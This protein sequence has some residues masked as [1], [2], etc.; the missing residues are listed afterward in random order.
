MPWV[1]GT[2]RA[3]SGSGSTGPS[4][5]DSPWMSPAT[6]RVRS[7]GRAHPAANGT[8]AM[9]PTRATA[10]ALR[11][12]FS[13]VWFPATVRHREQLY[14][15]AAVGEQ[16]R[17]GV[18]VPGVAVEEDLAGHGGQPF[19]GRCGRRANLSD[20]GPLVA[21]SVDAVPR[22]GGDGRRA[23]WRTAAP[24]T[25]TQSDHGPLDGIRV[26]DFST[27]Y[28]GPITAMLL[29]D[30]GADVLKIELPTRGPGPHPRLVR[31]EQH[32]IHTACGGR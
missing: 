12:T 4:S 29:G 14:L 6:P 21:G 17:D 11:V 13:R 24:M 25:S 15:R 9:P 19:R 1:Q 28:A 26:L 16:Q 5:P 3:G 30:Y 7:S 31:A 10:T 18:V 32:G 22:G 8:P 20:E 27:V 23:T 2:S